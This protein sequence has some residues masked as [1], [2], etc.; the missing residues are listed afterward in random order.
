[1]Q[2]PT[3][4]GEKLVNFIC[5]PSAT[6]RGTVIGPVLRWKC[7]WFNIFHQY[8]ACLEQ[9]DV[10]GLCLRMIYDL[11]GENCGPCLHR[12]QHFVSPFPGL[13]LSCVYRWCIVCVPNCKADVKIKFTA[14]VLR[15]R[16]K[17][18]L[19]FFQ[20]FSNLI[21]VPGFMYDCWIAVIFTSSVILVTANWNSIG[22]KFKTLS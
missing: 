10:G 18:K 19:T 12:F 1:M 20:I 6:S 17:K 5:S 21:F 11:G 3:F 16:L 13:V 8:G 2:P 7:P 4:S 15:P 9:Y 22:W 14:R